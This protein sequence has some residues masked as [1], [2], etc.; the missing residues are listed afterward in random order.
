MSV[1]SNE[2]PSIVLPISQSVCS[3]IARPL[4][5]IAVIIG[6]TL[7]G[8]ALFTPGWFQ[9]HFSKTGTSNYGIIVQSRDDLWTVKIIKFD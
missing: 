8:I 2:I 5:F 6:T 3:Y 7:T 4:F 1:E 9:M